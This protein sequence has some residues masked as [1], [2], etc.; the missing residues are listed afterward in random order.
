MSVLTAAANVV[1]MELPY[2]PPH[3][4]R[5]VSRWVLR[6]S[7]MSSHAKIAFTLVHPGFGLIC[8]SVTTLRPAVIARKGVLARIRLAL[9]VASCLTNSSARSST[10]NS[11][12]IT[13]DYITASVT[14]SDFPMSCCNFPFP[15]V[16]DVFT[17]SCFLMTQNIR[18]P[19]G[20]PRSDTF[21]AR[22]HA[23]GGRHFPGGHRCP[24]LLA[25]SFTL[26]AFTLLPAVPYRCEFALSRIHLV[27]L[28][29]HPSLFGPTP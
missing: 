3:V 27:A 9:W 21:P 7:R 20:P 16:R 14:N 15:S 5:N 13:S 17:G 24:N 29:M 4:G 19:L 23:R 28:S 18:L 11:D 22:T 2:V 25:A 10:R 8:L 12:R 1:L 6:A 26:N